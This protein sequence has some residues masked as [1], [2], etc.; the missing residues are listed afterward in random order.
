MYKCPE[1]N[2]CLDRAI[3]R[4]K[5]VLYCVVCNKIFELPDIIDLKEISKGIVNEENS[6]KE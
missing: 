6:Y 1:C 2:E 3:Y 4:G 5:V